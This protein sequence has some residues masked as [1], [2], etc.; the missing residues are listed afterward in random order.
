MKDKDWLVILKIF[1]VIF[2]FAIPFIAYDWAVNLFQK[3][4]W[5]RFIIF[6][7]VAMISTGCA[8]AFIMMLGEDRWNGDRIIIV[9]ALFIYGIV[10]IIGN[11]AQISYFVT[12]WHWIAWVI[13]IIVWIFLSIPTA[14]S[15]YKLFSKE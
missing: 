3:F 9:I 11:F 5:A 2:I 8:T 13:G 14:I 10:A 4:W 15:V 7:F 1:A 6:P 12:S